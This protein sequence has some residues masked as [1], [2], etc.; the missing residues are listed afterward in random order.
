MGWTVPSVLEP[1]LLQGWVV[2]N[3]SITEQPLSL[4]LIAEE[5]IKVYFLPP[6]S[7]KRKILDENVANLGFSYWS[8]EQTIAIKPQGMDARWKKISTRLENLCEAIIESNHGEK[9]TQYLI[10]EMIK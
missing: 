1:P 8:I 7:L 4:Y 5:S 10:L 2:L 9:Q 3:G 6:P